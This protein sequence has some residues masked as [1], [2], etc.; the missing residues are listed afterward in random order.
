MAIAIRKA[1][2][3]ILAPNKSI[4]NIVPYPKTSNEPLNFAKILADKA[5]A[6]AIATIAIGNNNIATGLVFSS[7]LI[8][9]AIPKETTANIPAIKIAVIACPNPIGLI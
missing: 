4:L 5:I 6:N 7:E 2:I 9:F 8:N 1:I 3:L